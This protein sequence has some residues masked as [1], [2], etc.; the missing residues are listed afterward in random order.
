ML[1]VGR[2][3]WTGSSNPWGKAVSLAVHGALLG[4]LLLEG[5]HLP[6]AITGDNRFNRQAMPY[7]DVAATPQDE[8][9]EETA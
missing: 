8:R 3:G 2:L 6:G 7:A 5:H 1:W 4:T 9:E